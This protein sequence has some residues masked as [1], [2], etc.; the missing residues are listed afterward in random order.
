[1]RA[2]HLDCLTLARSRERRSSRLRFRNCVV[3]HLANCFHVDRSAFS[4]GQ[5]VLNEPHDFLL[6][7]ALLS[8]ARF[9]VAADRPV[10]EAA[11]DVG[12]RSDSGTLR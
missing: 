4:G 12:K 5:R 3:N 9:A 2:F 7:D 1:M 11:R 8:G 10:T 6:R